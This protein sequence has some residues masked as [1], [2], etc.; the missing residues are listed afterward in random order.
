[1][2][3][4]RPL[5]FIL[6]FCIGVVLVCIVFGSRRSHQYADDTV[7]ISTLLS[8]SIHLTQ[9]AGKEVVSVR[10]NNDPEIQAKVKGHTSEGA[11]EYVTLGDQK[12][13]H[14]IVGGLLAQWPSL[15]LRSEEVGVAMEPII[16]PLLNKQVAKVK[17]RDEEVDIDDVT[18]W[19]DPLDA[20]QEYTEGG[21]QSDLLQYVTVM[22]CIVVGKYP[23]AGVVHQPF[24]KGNQLIHHLP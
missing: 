20:T 10:Q 12:S 3:R 4:G 18:I 6:V 15:K 7:K 19:I 2:L 9:L 11:K 24:V 21:E 23:V 16:F 5:M 14:L 1:M 13:N 8:A 22:I 17:E